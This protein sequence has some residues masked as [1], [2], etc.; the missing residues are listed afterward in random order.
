MVGVLRNCGCIMNVVLKPE[1]EKFVEEGVSLK[2][3]ASVD[4]MVAEG[5]QLLRERELAEAE[6]LAALRA[7]LQEAHDS[8]DRGEGVEMNDVEAFT[9]DFLATMHAKHAARQRSA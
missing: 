7:G 4:A 1:L 5:L 2:R 3:Y 9:K 6:K 8:L